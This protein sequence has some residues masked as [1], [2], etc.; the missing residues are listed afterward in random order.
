M[1]SSK[2]QTKQ[3]RCSQRWHTTGKRNEC[4]NYQIR[5]MMKYFHYIHKTQER[6]NLETKKI[7]SIRYPFSDDEY[8]FEWTEN[9]D[10]KC[11]FMQKIIYF[12]FKFVVNSGGAQTR[13]LR[14]NYHFIKNQPMI[15][16]VIYINI[17]DGDESYKRIKHFRKFCT[18]QKY[19]GDSYNF[20]SWY[21]IV[22]YSDIPEVLTSIILDYC[23]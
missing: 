14:E 15:T 7:K 6:I 11:N 20:P 13:T 17:L 12:N 3:W 16:N 22:F 8:A 23:F 21:A 19:V 9:F 18:L 10:G 4:E 5:S 1:I 2:H